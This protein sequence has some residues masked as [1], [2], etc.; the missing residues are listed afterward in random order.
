MCHCSAVRSAEGL[1]MSVRVR[2]LATGMTVGMAVMG[3]DGSV[4][5]DQYHWIHRA[6]NTRETIAVI[7]GVRRHTLS[8]GISLRSLRA[9]F[10][11]Q[12]HNSSK[13]RYAA[14]GI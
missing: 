2:N 6:A 8:C 7:N 12:V 9:I 4:Q 11:V 5:K 1:R 10:P 14:W 13:S 3:V